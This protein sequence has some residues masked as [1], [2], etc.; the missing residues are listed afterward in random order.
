MKNNKG[1]TLIVLVVTIIVLIIL[2]GISI[3]MLTG[4]NGIIKQSKEAKLQAEIKTEIEMIDL[5]VVDA[6]NKNGFGEL[7]YEG[8][9]QELD[10]RIKEEA[11]R[12]Y[13][14]SPQTDAKRYI[15]TYVDTQRSYEVN[16]NGE[17]KIHDGNNEEMPE[18]KNYHATID[19]NVTSYNATLGK[20]PVIFSVVGEW[21]G[22]KVYDNIVSTTIDSVGIS[23]I[24]VNVNVPEGTILKVSE[25]YS[26]ANYKIDSQTTMQ[27]ELAEEGENIKFSF[28][29][30][31]NY[32]D[33]GTGYVESTLKNNGGNLEYK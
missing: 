6:M 3:S 7:K 28:S 33:I 2:A 11:N 20:Y 9:K 24:D 30:S 27:E 32:C 10:K 22:T 23:S 29:N 25:V 14:I 21:N 16:A 5:S 19:V 17:I 8:L 12:D 13:T 1:I 26:G 31:Y 18:A 15:I 4:E